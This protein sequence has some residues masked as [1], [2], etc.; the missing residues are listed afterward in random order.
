[1]GVSWRGQQKELP[2]LIRERVT[3]ARYSDRAIMA[4]TSRM[5]L[6]SKSK[7]AIVISH[8]SALLPFFWVCI[9]EVYYIPNTIR[10]GVTSM[11]LNRKTVSQYL[12]NKTYF[13][14][15]ITNCFFVL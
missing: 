3:I 2:T 12:A 10:N 6:V 9:E 14:T 7:T 13:Y 15:T 5:T 8:C 4:R 1:L 11:I